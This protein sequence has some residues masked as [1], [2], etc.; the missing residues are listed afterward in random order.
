MVKFLVEG[1]A[2]P[3]LANDKNYIPLD[4]ASFGEKMDVV[5]YFLSQSG[6]LEGEN[7]GGLSGATEGMDIDAGE[8]EREDA[9][10]EG[11]T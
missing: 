5:D 2:S 9:A 1:G 11:K 3:A 7:E 8:K 10:E 6:G 4:L